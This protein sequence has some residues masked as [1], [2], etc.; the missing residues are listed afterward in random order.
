MKIINYNDQYKSM[1]KS[2]QLQQW[3]LSFP[4]G[5]SCHRTPEYQRKRKTNMSPITSWGMHNKGRV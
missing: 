4:T 2:L 5:D 3:I 1:N